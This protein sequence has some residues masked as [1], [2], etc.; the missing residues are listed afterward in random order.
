MLKQVVDLPCHWGRS[1]QTISSPDTE[2]PWAQ[3]HWNKL[4][5]LASLAFRTGRGCCIRGNG[6]GLRVTTL[7]SERWGRMVA[8]LGIL[9]LI[10]GRGT[11]QHSRTVTH[12]HP[13][14]TPLL[15]CGNLLF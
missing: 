4:N 12:P 2:P 6:L 14:P 5:Q 3:C 7:G 8:V 11:H 15:S 13:S 1:S 9:R 10:S